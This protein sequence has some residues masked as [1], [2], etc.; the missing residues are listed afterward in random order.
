MNTKREPVTIAVTGSFASG[1]STF[2][3]ML[4]ELGAETVS[5]DELVHEL[6]SDD[7]ET[8]RRVVERFGHEILGETGVDRKALG[9]KVFGEPEALK[10]LEDMLHPLVRRET[11]RRMAGSKSQIFVAEIPLLFEGTRSAAFDYTVAVLPP[12]ERRKLW[13]GERGVGEE[14]LR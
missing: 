14:R 1:K 13:A 5:S 11:D 7:A 3:K 6:L 9:G 4:G 12:E 2:V 8:I 10:D